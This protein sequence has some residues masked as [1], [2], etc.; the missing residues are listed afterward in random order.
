[1]SIVAHNIRR[2]L[3]AAS[4]LSLLVIAPPAL[5]QVA[6]QPCNAVGVTKMNAAQTEVLACLGDKVWHRGSTSSVNLNS[7]PVCTQ[8]GQALHF[9]G[10]NFQCATINTPNNCPSGQTW[11]GTACVGSSGG[12]NSGGSSCASN[13]YDNCGV[14]DGDGSSCSSSGGGSGG[15]GGCV[16]VWGD[17]EPNGPPFLE[18]NGDCVQPLM[19]YS[20]NCNNQSQACVGSL[21]SGCG[22]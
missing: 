1:M 20:T 15:G 3:I 17:C 21:T 14:C 13:N 9:D 18:G 6:G 5:A 19:R 16:P 12:T 22:N 2:A 7:I 4:I 8:Q 11:N 10:T